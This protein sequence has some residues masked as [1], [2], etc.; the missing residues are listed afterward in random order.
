[1]WWGVHQ[2]MGWWMLIGGLWM[3]FFWGAIILLIVWGI[4]ALTGRA[5]EP[6]KPEDPLAIAQIRYARG[7]ITNEEFERIKAAVTSQR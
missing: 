5:P 1:M 2:G 7:E 3:L 4:R 6:P